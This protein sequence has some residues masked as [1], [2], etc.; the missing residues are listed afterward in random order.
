[1]CRNI[2]SVSSPLRILALKMT[3]VSESLG[4]FL[5]RRREPIGW[6][7]MEQATGLQDRTMR[8]YELGRMPPLDVGL[9]I[10]EAL[11]VPLEEL[12][13][14]V[15][16][17]PYRV[18]DPPGPPEVGT[19]SGGV[20]AP[21]DLPTAIAGSAAAASALGHGQASPSRPQRARRRREPP[22]PGPGE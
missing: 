20:P 4:Q 16:G 3:L 15:L 19:A 1:M 13:E 2:R 12:A 11:G 14:T 7:R 18:S 6:A 10:G 8:N 21:F 5:R 22:A 9:R 17:R